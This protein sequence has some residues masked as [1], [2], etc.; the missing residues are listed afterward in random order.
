MGFSDMFK[1]KQYKTELG[2]LQQKYDELKSMLTP[3][4]QDILKQKEVLHIGK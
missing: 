3:E 2:A 4:M 1:G